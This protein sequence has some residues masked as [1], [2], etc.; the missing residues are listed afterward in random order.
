MPK[1][2]PFLHFAADSAARL[3]KDICMVHDSDNLPCQRPASIAGRLAGRLAAPSFVIPAGVAEN[4]RFLANKVDEVGL[5]LFETRACLNYGPQDLPPDL[6]SLPLRWHAHLPV[7]LPWP[8][9]S[10]ATHPARTTSALARQVLEKAAFLAP[11]CAVL[12]PPAGT[13]RRQRRLLAGFAHHWQKYC[14]VPLLLENVAHSDIWGLGQGF[15]QDHGLGLCLDV[16]HLLGYGQKNLLF[17]ALPEQAS[18]VHWS[19][20]GDGDRHMPLTAFTGPQMQTA[21]DLMARFSATAVHMAEI[22]R[23]K[24]LAESLPVLEA[25]SP[26]NPAR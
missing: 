21:A 5:C 13:P 4:A 19:A 2:S 10:S 15:L 20:P 17:S 11:S 14:H 1:I 23:W 8:V 26:P 24:G 18:L 16:G 6:A 9:K 7:D 22:F 12:H 3:L 25:L